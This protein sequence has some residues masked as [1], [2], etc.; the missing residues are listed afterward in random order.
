MASKPDN[1]ERFAR[2]GVPRVWEPQPRLE[3][4]R[5]PQGSLGTLKGWAVPGRGGLSL[6]C[7]LPRPALLAV[8]WFDGYAG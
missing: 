4:F 3:R 7:E 1:R 5:I 8:P 6:W 2:Y